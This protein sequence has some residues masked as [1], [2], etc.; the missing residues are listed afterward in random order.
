MVLGREISIRIWPDSWVVSIIDW[1]IAG[2]DPKE[3]EDEVSPLLG[4]EFPGCLSTMNDE[5][6]RLAWWRFVVGAL[7]K[8][9]VAEVVDGQLALKEPT[10]Q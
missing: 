6:T 1:E 9:R 8:W 10:S 5:Y 2:Y 4:G 3:C 7:A